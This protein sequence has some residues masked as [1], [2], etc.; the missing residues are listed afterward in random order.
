MLRGSHLWN[1]GFL[2]PGVDVVLAWSLSY[3]ISE[4]TTLAGVL[5]FPFGRK[6]KVEARDGRIGGK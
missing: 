6:N 1:A 5:G 3:G 4:P 2:V